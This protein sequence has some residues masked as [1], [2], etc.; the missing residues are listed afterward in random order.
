MT[1]KRALKQRVRARMTRTGE[2]YT[3]AHRHVV[4][5]RRHRH[6]ESALVRRML[7]AAGVEVSEAMVCG[8]G[9]GI[10]FMYAVFEYESVDHPL[11]TIVTQHH[12]TPWVEAVATHLGVIPTRVTSSST[13]PAFERLRR[14][15]DTGR[16]VLVEVARGLLPWQQDLSEAEAAD[17]HALLVVG[18]A[19]DEFVVLD[20]DE[21]RVEQHVL[22]AAWSGHRKGRFAVT[23]LPVAEV[24]DLAAAASRAVATTHAHLTGP[25]L[26]HAFDVNFGLSGIARLRDDLA[27]TSTKRGWSRRFGNEA[28]FAVARM[29]LAEC[30]TWA[31]GAEGATRLVYADFLTETG[32]HAAATLAREAGRQWSS[33]ADLAAGDADST[34][35]L[36]ELADR[37]AAVY[38]VEVTLVDALRAER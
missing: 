36:T 35:A 4:A 32:R 1:Q 27:D 12:P 2:S 17:P 21:H 13:A 33:I 9:G 19:A 5:P 16:P 28:A 8:L 25:V 7:S 34:T 11:L 38:D 14:A 24:P 22:G 31:H 30:L 3:T 29:R 37:V 15:L 26:G 10:G 23:T 18:C 6:R 20:R